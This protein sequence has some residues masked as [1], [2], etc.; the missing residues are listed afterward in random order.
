MFDDV[1]ANSLSV[2]YTRATTSV[3][4]FQMNEPLTLNEMM[5]KYVSVDMFSH[6]L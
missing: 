5:Y 4:A 1:Y 2:T 3:F 6:I